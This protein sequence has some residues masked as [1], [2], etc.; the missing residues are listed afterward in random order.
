MEINEQTTLFLTIS[1]FD[2]DNLPVVP[3][4]ATYRIDDVLSGTVILADTALTLASVVE[5]IITQA[6]NAIIA[7]VNPVE[8]RIV[9]VEYNYGGSY[10]GTDEYRYYV[11][12][13]AGVA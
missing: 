7:S 4:S 13:L 1:F 8:T 9:T 11:K 3:D 12:S 10:H 5:V 2:Q 6:Q